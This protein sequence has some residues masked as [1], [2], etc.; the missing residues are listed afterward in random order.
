MKKSMS[1]V[2]LSQRMLAACFAGACAVAHAGYVDERGQARA[3]PVP[4][5][6]AQQAPSSAA[7]NLGPEFSA[8]VWLESV[9]QPGDSVTLGTALVMLW[10][11]ALPALELD[12]PSELLE[13]KV[14]WKAGETR[15]AILQRAATQHQIQFRMAGRRISAASI[16]LPPS[17]AAAATPKAAPQQHFD[18]LLSDIKLATSFD[19]WAKAAGVRVRWDAD[20]HVLI[21]APM[22]YTGDVADAIAAALSSDSIQQSDYPLEVCEYPNEPRLLRITRLGD[23]AKA[24]PV[25]VGV[26]G[27]NVPPRPQ[28]AVGVIP[29]LPQGVGAPAPASATLN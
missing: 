1:S 2:T 9:T 20:R 19:R 17:A 10:P 24:C 14:S 28:A 13:R 15:Q 6:S 21:G 18:V 12:M 11:L 26:P 3:I 23:Q 16:A 22:S 25:I 4:S 5:Q 27:G 8:P 29:G 7:A